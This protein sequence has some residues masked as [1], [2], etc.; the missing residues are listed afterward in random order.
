MTGFSFVRIILK[1]LGDEYRYIDRAGK[2]HA[3]ANG[4]LPN[5]L[6]DELLVAGVPN[7]EFGVFRKR[8]AQI[9]DKL[10]MNTTEF[11]RATTMSLPMYLVQF[12]TNI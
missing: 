2:M 8:A 11:Q 9:V 3:L 4:K 5:N 1:R 12:V 10:L 6:A 7:N